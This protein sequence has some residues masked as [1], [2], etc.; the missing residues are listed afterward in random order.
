[1]T[2]NPSHLFLVSKREFSQLCSIGQLCHKTFLRKVIDQNCR[3]GCANKTIREMLNSL[4][5]CNQVIVPH[6]DH[7]RPSNVVEKL[8]SIVSFQA[9][10]CAKAMQLK[11]TPKMMISAMLVSMPPEFTVRILMLKSSGHEPQKCIHG[12]SIS[13]NIFVLLIIPRV[14][15][16]IAFHHDSVLHGAI[17]MS[18]VFCSAFSQDEPANF[19]IMTK[20]SEDRRV[21]HQLWVP[22]GYNYSRVTNI[23]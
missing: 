9:C 19:S 14:V 18:N 1:M 6:P 4:G 3:C 17:W 15:A 8:M 23:L 13:A 20:V 7:L 21:F 11:N 2:K 5:H 22:Y 16:N 12:K 10:E